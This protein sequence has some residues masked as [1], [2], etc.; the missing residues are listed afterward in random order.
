MSIS[1]RITEEI[2]AA[3]ITLVTN[4]LDECRIALKP[5]LLGLTE[6]ERQELFKMGNKTV[7][8]I[9]KVKTYIDTNPEFVP[10]YMQTVEFDK[11][12]DV[13][14]QLTPIHNVAFQLASD[15]DDTRML[16]GSEALAEALI[17]YGAVREAANKG[18]V[19]AKPIY[20]ELRER[21]TKRNTPK[22]E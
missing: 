4:K 7:S 9:Q 8:T 6:K 1:N 18:I 19:Q 15:L 14:N 10:S 16:V 12:V 2:P 13:V 20:D 3:V 17:Y 22:K 21:F 11:D 5:Y